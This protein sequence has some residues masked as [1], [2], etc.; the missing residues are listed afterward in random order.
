MRGLGHNVDG[1]SRRR[2]CAR[3]AQSS[4]FRPCS[5]HLYVRNHLCDLGRGLSL[6]GLDSEATNARL[7]ATRMA[8]VQETWRISQSGAYRIFGRNAPPVP[9]FHRK[10]IDT[11][12]DHASADFLGLSVSGSDYLSTSLRMDLL[13]Q[14][15]QRPD[16]IR[17]SPVRLSRRTLS[18]AHAHFVVALPWSRYCSFLGPGRNWALPLAA[19]AR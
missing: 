19:Y 12:L 5:R 17:N 13:H 10:A 8:A 14:R 11:A 6:F 1:S 4:E 7:L 2:H 18:S 9:N 3:L 16:G 15:S